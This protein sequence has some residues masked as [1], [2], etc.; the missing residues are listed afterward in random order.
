MEIQNFYL[1]S[2]KNFIIN[3]NDRVAQM[4]LTP[5]LKMELEET[6]E[7]GSAYLA[8]TIPLKGA[9]IKSSSPSTCI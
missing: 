9:R 3:N 2:L 8:V 4:I 7:P 1:T 6:N 5:I